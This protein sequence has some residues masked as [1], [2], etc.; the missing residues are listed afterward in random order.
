MR[1]T[2]PYLSIILGLL[3]FATNAF[4]YIKTVLTIASLL[5]PFRIFLHCLGKDHEGSRE[6]LPVILSV[7]LFTNYQ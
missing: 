6:H 7:T 5:S 1:L 3:I 2:D 4:I